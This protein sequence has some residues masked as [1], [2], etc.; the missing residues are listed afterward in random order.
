MKKWFF[1]FLPFILLSLIIFSTVDLA[2]IIRRFLAE[3]FG[4]GVYNGAFV[5]VAGFLAFS[6]YRVRR[7][8]DRFRLRLF[9]MI[10]VFLLYALA[11][12]QLKYAVEKIHYLEYGLLC[13]LAIR[14][15]SGD[16]RLPAALLLSLVLTFSIG[17]VDEFLQHL[18]PDRVAEFR[19]VFTNVNAGVLGLALYLTQERF[20]IRRPLFLPF[21]KRACLV[22]LA[23]AL[24]L[25]FAFVETVHGFGYRIVDSEKAFFYSSFTG[26]GL[27]NLDKDLKNGL[28][29][30]PAYENEA[31]RHLFQRNFYQANR[32]MINKTE[33]YMEPGKSLREN[34]LLEKYFPAF[35]DKKA[36]RWDDSTLAAIHRAGDWYLNTRWNSRVKETIIVSVPAWI[37]RLGFLLCLGLCGFFWRRL[38]K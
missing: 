19:D 28:S 20:V 27:L 13:V 7:Q 3:T 36:A 30:P 4:E 38:K 21:E 25:S 1:R 22:A 8:A 29:V 37:M 32:F 17:L 35:L 12:S 18:H 33:Y 5:A 2:G 15:L 26:S 23:S 34:M 16:C 10:L 6:V 14:A 11:L 31:E 24:V 9:I